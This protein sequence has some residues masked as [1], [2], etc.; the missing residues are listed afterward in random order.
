MV[1]WANTRILPACRA[2]GAPEA[3]QRHLGSLP[4][5]LW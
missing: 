2:A 3:W 5:S 1:T 4:V